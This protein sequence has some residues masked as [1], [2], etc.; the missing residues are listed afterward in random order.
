[1]SLISAGSISL[2]S[3][4]KLERT[5]YD[6]SSSFHSDINICYLPQSK[7][8]HRVTTCYQPGQAVWRARPNVYVCWSVVRLKNRRWGEACRT[9][10]CAKSQQGLVWLD[11]HEC[12]VTIVERK[13]DLWLSRRYPTRRQP[14]YTLILFGVGGRCRGRALGMKSVVRMQRAVFI[15]IAEK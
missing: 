5:K 8:P 14:S 7:A 15:K 11:M 10:R 1:M 9:K 3:T 13:D 2:D 4:F 12:R 6:I